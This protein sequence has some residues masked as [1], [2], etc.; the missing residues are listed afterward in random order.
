MIYHNSIFFN[1]LIIIALVGTT[2]QFLKIKTK[3]KLNL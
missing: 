2:I 3:I 1:L